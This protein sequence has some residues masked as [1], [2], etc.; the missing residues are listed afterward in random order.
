VIANVQD[1]TNGPP[2]SN[3]PG[4]ISDIGEALINL[5]QT[6]PILTTG[7][8][9]NIQVKTALLRDFE[10]FELRANDPTTIT[11]Q[12]FTFLGVAGSRKWDNYATAK[13]DFKLQSF[14][15]S[16]S[17]ENTEYCCSDKLGQHLYAS[18]G[19]PVGETT[20][21]NNATGAYYLFGPWDDFI[22][23]GYAP[24]IPMNANRGYFSYNDKRTDCAPIKPK[25]MQ[26]M[27]GLFSES[28][29]EIIIFTND[30][31]AE[32]E[33]D[34]SNIRSSL[35]T[36]IS[37]ITLDLYPNPTHDY[38]NIALKDLNLNAKIDLSIY[39]T[40]GQLVETIYEGQ[41]SETSKNMTWSNNEI[42]NGTYHLVLRENNILIFGKAFVFSK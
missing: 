3:I 32:T 38:L 34:D 18:M 16:G 15:L 6:P 8:C 36:S 21:N 1:T 13:S 7:N 39:N 41:V 33:I 17:I 12:S 35:S 29:D 24:V 23:I 30:E 14:V 40:L 28:F 9:E 20:H 5:F 42:P 31:V 4:A 19:G 2:I 26:D 25:S 11:L 27:S 22:Q 37:N 10:C